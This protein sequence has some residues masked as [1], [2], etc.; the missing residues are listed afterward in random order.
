MK[1]KDIMSK[2]VYLLDHREIAAIRKGLT[3]YMEELKDYDSPEAK[4]EFLIAKKSYNKFSYVEVPHKLQ[5]D[6]LLMVKKHYLKK[7]TEA[8]KIKHFS[9][10]KIKCPCGNKLIIGTLEC[11]SCGTQFNKKGEITNP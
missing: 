2:E 4:E 7:E 11:P 10:K 8:S 1:S 3:K 6:F 9:K 5:W